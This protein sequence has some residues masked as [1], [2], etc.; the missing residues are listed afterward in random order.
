MDVHASYQLGDGCYQQNSDI[1]KPW[2]PVA[3]C[4]LSGGV[5]QF[6]LYHTPYAHLLF[7]LSRGCGFKSRATRKKFHIKFITRT[8][9]QTNSV[10]SS[11]SFSWKLYLISFFYYQT[12]KSKLFHFFTIPPV[13]QLYLI[14]FLAIFPLSFPESYPICCPLWLVE[15]HKTSLYSLPS[16]ALT[17]R[18]CL[19]KYSAR[20]WEGGLAESVIPIWY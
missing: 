1:F 18:R 17:W 4:Y 5:T 15:N 16:N 11:Q 3:S 13:L 8:L 2:R 12:F 7:F 6:L 10:S 9:F 20:S 14:S 19:E